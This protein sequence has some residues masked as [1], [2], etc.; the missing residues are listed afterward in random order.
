MGGAGEYSCWWLLVVWVLVGSGGGSWAQVDGNTNGLSDVWETAYGA[1]G[2]ALAGDADGDGQSNYQESVAGMDPFDAQS[3]FQIAAAQFVDAAYLIQWSSVA[4]KRYQVEATNVLSG[5]SWLP[6]GLPVSGTG[7]FVWAAV[8]H[9]TPAPEAFRL[10]LLVDNPAIVNGR[11]AL[12]GQETD[13]DGVADIDEFAAGTDPFDAGSFLAIASLTSGPA[14][15]LRWPSVTG[16]RYQIQSRA[17]LSD[18]PWLEEGGVLGGDGTALTAVV[19]VTASNRFFRVGVSD[20]DSDLDGVTDWEEAVAGLAVGPWHYRTNAP[21]TAAAVATILAATNLINFEV[22]TAVANA[23]TLTPG[24]VRVTRAGNLNRLTVRYTV[25]GDAVPG[26]DYEALPGTITLPIGVNEVELP[27]TPL[28]EAVLAPAK[29]VV[30]TVSPDPAYVVGTNGSRAVSVV[31]EVALSVLDFGAVGDGATD[32][33]A[34]VQAALTALEAST[35][36]NT[37]HFPAG[38]YRLNTPTWDYDDLAGW[39][40]KLLTLGS[41][42]LAGRDLLMTADPGAVLYSTVSTNRTPILVAHTSFRSLTFRGLTWRKD[43]N[44]LP[45]T[46]GGEPNGAQGVWLKNR[47]LRQVAAVD[48]LDCT[49]ENCHGAVFTTGYGYDLRGKLAHFGFSRC[50]VLNPFGS[51]TTNAW[52]A[53]GGGQQVRLTPWVGYAIYRD[54]FFDGGSETPDPVKNP[55][56]IRKDG[57]HFGSPLRLLFTNNVVRRMGVEAVFQTDEPYMGATEITAAFT[58]PPADGASTAQV[59]L[60]P[61]PS[62][63]QAGQVVSFRTTL[64]GNPETV[65]VFLTV[66][67]YDPATRVLTLKNDGL[68][69]GAGGAVVPGW[70]IINLQ[71]YNPTLATIVGNIVDGGEPRVAF[72]IVSIA[73]ATIAG[74][75]IKGYVSGVYLYDSAANPLHP[76]TPGTVVDSNVILTQDSLGFVPWAY[77]IESYGPGEIISKN[78]IITPSTYRFVGIAVRGEDFWVEANTVIPRQVVR[79]SYGVTWRSVGIGFGNSTAGSTAVANRTYGM[80]VGIGPEKPYQI[81]PHRVISH[82]S[83]NDVLAIDP[84]GLMGN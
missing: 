9:G 28:A 42:E 16:K 40:Q 45:E 60:L 8:A 56:G 68:T 7:G 14:V 3:V 26:V 73:K 82:F 81:T 29:S 31:K 79:Q 37:L 22:G 55:G 49:F 46:V 21:T 48:F 77:G 69:P 23:T 19:V 52:K 62:T 50:R 61:I 51:N 43:G 4:G 65:N 64:A 32:D 33:T 54:N 1:A 5:G 84:R 57:S 17:D 10:R 71:D 34:A 41:N 36:H 44:L 25:S 12:L 38:T 58:V 74:N 72:G 47:D 53:Y 75:F 66:A 15:Q 13:G 20:G 30:L 6:Q 11:A 78:F 83:T 59:K 63:Y 80:D 35:N 76:P 70:A 24:S 2:L 27:V 18:G 67:G 39:Y